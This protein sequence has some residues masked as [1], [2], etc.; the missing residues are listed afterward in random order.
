M[1]KEINKNPKKI[2]WKIIL[3]LVVMTVFYCGVNLPI[4]ARDVIFTAF[5]VWF[6]VYLIKNY[7]T[8]YEYEL[9]EDKVVITAHLGDRIRGQ[10]VAEYGAIKIFD[11]NS[12]NEI[13]N[14]KCPT[15]KLCTSG[16]IK[17]AIVFESENGENKVIFA[18]G[19]QFVKILEDKIKHH[20]KE[21]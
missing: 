15:Q 3:F 1:Y 2:F 11:L 21:E 13:K 10:A 19:E 6:V 20:T 17:Y 14:I 7:L 5:A 8:V 18:P 16:K 4:L 9:F 12:S